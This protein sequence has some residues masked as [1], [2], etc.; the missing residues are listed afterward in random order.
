M[1]D[2]LRCI[3]MD[4]MRVMSSQHVLTGARCT[5]MHAQVPHMYE[6]TQPGVLDRSSSYSAHKY[7]NAVSRIH[8]RLAIQVV[9]AEQSA[10]EAAGVALVQTLDT[11]CGGQ[12][13]A[14]RGT[15]AS[16]PTCNATV[17]NALVHAHASQIL[18]VF[19]GLP[20]TIVNRF[21]SGYSDGSGVRETM[22]WSMCT[23]MYG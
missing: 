22:S 17:L 4:S 6:T 9:I 12:T 15:A 7:V 8:Y 16:P 14:V 18:D 23:Q 19:N 3:P 13:A 21:G 20:D 10:L 5:G 11:T 2:L 1:V